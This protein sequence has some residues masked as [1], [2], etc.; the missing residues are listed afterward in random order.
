MIGG[1]HIQNV[2]VRVRVPF[3]ARVR[4]HASRRSPTQLVL[5][6]EKSKTH[7]IRDWSRRGSWQHGFYRW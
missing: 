3:R 7:R 5:D 2:R 4:V 6:T 1:T